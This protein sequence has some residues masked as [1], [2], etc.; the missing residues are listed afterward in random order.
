M[1]VLW[2]P[3]AL[4]SALDSRTIQSFLLVTTNVRRV[5]G[6]AAHLPALI[7]Q[8]ARVTAVLAPFGLD[9]PFE[10]LWM[11]RAYS[12]IGHTH[13]A[14]FQMARSGRWLSPI[15]KQVICVSG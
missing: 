12:V 14:F 15:S 6:Q 2:H 1:P 11:R 9:R 13:Q 5:F 7:L 8:G 4:G 10:M 3:V